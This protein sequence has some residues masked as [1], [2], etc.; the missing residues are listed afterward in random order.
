MLR[1]SETRQA[2]PEIRAAILF[3]VN[4]F[5]VANFKE[6]NSFRIDNLENTS[7]IPA[8]S[9]RKKPLKRSCKMFGVQ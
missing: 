5:A 6:Q 4:I 1:W 7:M 2:V 8:Y 3:F 9:K